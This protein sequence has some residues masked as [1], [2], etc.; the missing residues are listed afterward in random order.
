MNEITPN[1]KVNMMCYLTYPCRHYVTLFGETKLMNSEKIYD[2]FIENNVPVIEHFA[3]IKKIKDNRDFLDSVRNGN[4]DIDEENINIYKTRLIHNVIISDANFHEQQKFI[5]YLVKE[6]NIP[7][8]YHNLITCAKY[9]KLF[10]MFKYLANGNIN[11]LKRTGQHYIAH[12][13]N[14]ILSAAAFNNNL[15]AVKYMIEDL[16]ISVAVG[17]NPLI[18]CFCSK[19]NVDKMKT[20]LISKC[21][22][23]KIVFYGYDVSALKRHNLIDTFQKHGLIY[24]HDST[25]SIH[26]IS[27][28]LDQVSKILTDNCI[29]GEKDQLKENICHV[30]LYNNSKYEYFMRFTSYISFHKLKL[31]VD[32]NII[33]DIYLVFNDKKLKFSKSDECNF[34]FESIDELY[35]GAT[36]TQLSI[37]FETNNKCNL[38]PFIKKINLEI[39]GAFI[40][41]SRK[42]SNECVFK[43]DNDTFIY[44]AFGCCSFITSTDDNKNDFCKRGIELYNRNNNENIESIITI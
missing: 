10:D 7:I 4:F 37:L 39:Y 5:D 18:E 21:V 19:V 11:L 23:Q 28:C 36:Y 43:I 22:E 44:R 31:S 33:S 12:G 14:T 8:T 29:S 9:E 16:N 34:I 17:K 2:L 25:V 41:S 24:N 30:K 35:L 32:N 6:K 1:I 3:Y 20:Y 40:E 13:G 26:L 38:N 42:Y 27:T 15:L